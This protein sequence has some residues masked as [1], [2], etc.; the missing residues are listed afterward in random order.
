MAY[1]SMLVPGQGSFPNTGPAERD[2][3]GSLK[4]HGQKNIPVA[5]V[6]FDVL[7]VE[8]LSTMR[9]PYG[10]RREILE[11]LDFGA[12]CHICPR[13]DDGEALWESVC[14]RELRESSPRN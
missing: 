2:L 6:L 1:G 11:L 8:G 12:G 14:E 5:L 13:F 9:Q 3:A 4:L 10:E 7:E